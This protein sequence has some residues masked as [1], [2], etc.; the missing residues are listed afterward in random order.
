MTHD[1]RYKPD[2]LFPFPICHQVREPH[3]LQL[4][5]HKKPAYDTWYPVVLSKH[6]IQLLDFFSVEM[7]CGVICPHLELTRNI[8]EGGKAC[9]YERKNVYSFQNLDSVAFKTL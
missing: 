4:G 5:C 1:L 2:I 9:Y 8:W 7:I 6:A 3:E